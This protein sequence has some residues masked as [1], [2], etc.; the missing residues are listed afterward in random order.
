M[1]N[2]CN[3]GYR[4]AEQITQA[5]KFKRT[6]FEVMEKVNHHINFQVFNVVL[7][8]KTNLLG[9]IPADGSG[10]SIHFAIDF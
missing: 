4:V 8:S 10:L 3:Q 1:E 6:Q 9:K 7:A 5:F 2:K